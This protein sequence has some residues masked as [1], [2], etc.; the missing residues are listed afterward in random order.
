MTLER[1]NKAYNTNEQGLENKLIFD[2]G[3]IDRSIFK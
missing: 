1:M 3:L 2:K